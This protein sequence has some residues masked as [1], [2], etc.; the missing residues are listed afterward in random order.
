MEHCEILNGTGWKFY[1]DDT[2][3][4]PETDS[5][6]LSSFPRLKPGLRVFDLGAGTGL[7]ELLLLRRQRKLQIAGLEFHAGAAALAEKNITENGL[8]AALS[9]QCGDLRRREDLPGAGAFDL[10]VCNPPY[11]SAGSGVSSG[12]A[13]RRTAREEISCTLENV[14][15]AAA[16]LLRWGGAFCL[17]HRP[18]RLADLVTALRAAGLEPKRLR[19]AVQHAGQPPAL[20]LLESR[21]GGHPGLSWEAPLY[22][23]DADGRATREIDAIYYRNGKDMP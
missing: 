13:A 22:L 21:R 9:V 14:C 11:F 7:L 18:E 17:V 8:S 15:S 1:Y 20:L 3:F 4:P 12:E 5:F 19:P 2:L 6:L 10:V 16:Y 23:T